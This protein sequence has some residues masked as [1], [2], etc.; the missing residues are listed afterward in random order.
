MALGFIVSYYL[1]ALVDSTHRATVLSFKGVAFNLVYGFISLSLPSY[2]GPFEMVQHAG[3][4][5]TRSGLPPIV[6]RVRFVHLRDLLPATAPTPVSH[7]DGMAQS[8]TRSAIIHLTRRCSDQARCRRDSS[9]GCM[10]DVEHRLV[11]KWRCRAG[12]EFSGG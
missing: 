2:Y 5:R 11:R 8:P 10:D 3:R 4:R 7:S 6:A 9:A 1:N 12:R